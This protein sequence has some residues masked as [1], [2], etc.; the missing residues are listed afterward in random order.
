MFSMHDINVWNVQILNEQIFLL[1][2]T[3]SW[4][5]KFV[6]LGWVWVIRTW[7]ALGLTFQTR[8]F[9]NVGVN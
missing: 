2:I 4:N 9:A 1:P 5:V 3:K 7:T 8:E 6:M